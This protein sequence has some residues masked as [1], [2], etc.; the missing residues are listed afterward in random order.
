[1]GEEFSE[2]GKDMHE[3][4]KI[5]EELHKRAEDISSD[6]NG[7]P[8]VIIV[9]GTGEIV[10]DKGV[11][12]RNMLGSSMHSGYRLRDLLG[13]LQTSIQIESLKHFFPT[14]W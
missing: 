7:A 13:M 2:G 6:Y 11:L 8:V 1:M 9:G 3:K 5:E 14:S 12:K 10:N 4:D